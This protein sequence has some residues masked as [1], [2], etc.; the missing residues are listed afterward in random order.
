MPEV[1]EHPAIASYDLIDF[2]PARYRADRHRRRWVVTRGA[3]VI[4]FAFLVVASIYAQHVR[5]SQL[6]ERLAKAN[7]RGALATTQSAR[8][9]ASNAQLRDA[10]TQ[11]KLFTFL[12]RPWPRTQIL[13]AVLEPLPPEVRLTSLEITSEQISGTT[14]RR[15]EPRRNANQPPDQRPLAERTLDELQTAFGQVQTV[16][17]LKGVTES[18]GELH[19]YIGRLSEN[20]LLQKPELRSLDG[21]QAP[22]GAQS[23]FDFK[24]TVV[25]PLGDVNLAAAK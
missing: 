13:A 23:R 3:V 11:A 12:R 6:R 20:K 18:N 8:L 19:R 7:E 14:P 10:T 17:V 5:V 16:V 25:P 24:I 22:D 9:T 15:L 2:L 21:D 4:V 1:S